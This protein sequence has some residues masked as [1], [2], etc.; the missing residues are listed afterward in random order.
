MKGRN[1]VKYGCYT[2]M[3]SHKEVSEEVK[4]IAHGVEEGVNVI[5]E[6]QGG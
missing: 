5:K 4:A 3:N 6:A 2:M 1:E